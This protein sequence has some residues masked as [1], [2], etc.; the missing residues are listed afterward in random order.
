[1][2]KPGLECIRMIPKPVALV[3][4]SSKA[5]HEIRISAGRLFVSEGGVKKVNIGHV[6]QPPP[7]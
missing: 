7:S 1:M 5:D 4:A 6:I 2:I 3:W